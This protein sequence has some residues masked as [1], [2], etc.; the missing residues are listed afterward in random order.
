[1]TSVISDQWPLWPSWRGGVGYGGRLVESVGP[2]I[3]P[4]VLFAKGR[5]GYKQSTS[6]PV[7]CV[8]CL[9]FQG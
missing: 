4:S 3:S 8:L 7:L 1:M 6:F 9:F 2:R 5:L